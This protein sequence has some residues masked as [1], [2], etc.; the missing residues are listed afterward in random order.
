MV[1]NWR[2]D[3]FTEKFRTA[4]L[5]Y[6]LGD[7]SPSFSACL[8]L[9]TASSGMTALLSSSSLCARSKL[10]AKAS[11]CM[12]R[13]TALE[14]NSSSPKRRETCHV[15]C[16]YAPRFA[17]AVRNTTGWLKH[18]SNKM[19]YRRTLHF[20]II[21]QRISSLQLRPRP[22][23]K[24]VHARA[25][26]CHCCRIKLRLLAAGAALFQLRRESLKLK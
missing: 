19:H 14:L 10:S 20:N 9:S 17:L 13:S 3:V 4:F 5:F 1:S 2:H 11:T 24:R 23:H 16:E 26:C 18:K 12:H 21:C 7:C 25:K 8:I 15:T 6:F 22:L